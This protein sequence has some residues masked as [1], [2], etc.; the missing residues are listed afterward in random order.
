MLKILLTLYIEDITRPRGDMKFLFEVN[1]FQH[2]KRNF[3]S[4]SCLLYKYQSYKYHSE[5][6][7]TLTK[8]PLRKGESLCYHNNGDLFTCEDNMLF[9]RVIFLVFHWCLYNKMNSV[10]ISIFLSS[11]NYIF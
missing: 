1:I 2:E 7:S 4:L 10:S 6:I 9:S 11:F 5:I 3:V 8:A